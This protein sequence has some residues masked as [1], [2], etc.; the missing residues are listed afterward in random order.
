[1]RKII[2]L[3]AV[4]LAMFAGPAWV[5]SEDT[6]IEQSASKQVITLDVCP[7]TLA[8]IRSDWSLIF[9][10][11]NKRLMLV[12]CEYYATKP[13]EVVGISWSPVSLMKWRLLT[14]STSF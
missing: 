14:A 6:V 10:L 8:H 9:P 5:T 2:A 3:G 11:E 4:I 13:S 1:M 7:S 12:W